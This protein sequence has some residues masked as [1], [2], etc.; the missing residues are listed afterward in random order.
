MRQDRPLRK[1]LPA[2]YPANPGAI[3][4]AVDPGHGGRYPGA[5]NGGFAEKDFNLD[6]GL[7]LQALLEHAGVQVVMSR[8]TDTAI[9]EPPTDHNGDGLFN[10]YDND[11][12][13]NDSKN[14]ARADVAVHVHN[15]GSSDPEAHGTGVYVRTRTWTPQATALATIMVQEQYGALLAYES[16]DFDAKLNGVLGGR[17]YYYMD[18]YDPP[19]LARPSLVTSVLSES[20]YVSNLQDREAL[21]RND[22]RTSLAAAIYLGLAAWLNSR[23]HGV[24]YE[25]VEAPSQAVGGTGVTYM[26]RVTNRGNLPTQGWSLRLGA[27]PAV[28]VY[29][30]SG[31]PGEQIGL[32][33]VPDG[34]APGASVDL[35]VPATAPATA[36]DWL[37]KA[38]IVTNGG[39]HLS[40]AGIVALQMPLTTTAP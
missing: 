39:S 17:F 6:I 13:R 27:V 37:V 21:R 28:P 10:R 9:D 38:D 5:V 20:L 29:D 2:I 32:V 25:A 4:I 22:V 24:G 26:L 31:A 14:L 12:L 11:L 40:D 16:P 30:G 18:P 3:V 1:G 8:T 36:G 33:S 19:F 15:N 34:L 23:D 7:K 35:S